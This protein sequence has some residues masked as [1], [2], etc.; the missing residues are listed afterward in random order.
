MTLV[1]TQK[2]TTYKA[3]HFYFNPAQTKQRDKTDNLMTT[4]KTSRHNRGSRYPLPLSSCN[5]PSLMQITVLTFK[6]KSTRLKPKHSEYDKYGSRP[7]KKG[8][9]T[10]VPGKI[11]HHRADPVAFL[12]TLLAF[13]TI[14]HKRWLFVLTDRT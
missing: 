7:G 14:H 3:A 4:Q 5:P 8:E 1:D 2:I 13:P 10:A 12:L 9:I 11:T 6:W